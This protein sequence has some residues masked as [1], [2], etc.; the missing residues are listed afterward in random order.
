MHSLKRNFIKV[1]TLLAISFALPTWSADTQI[2][3]HIEALS[4]D[5]YYVDI[6]DPNI[7]F[8]TQDIVGGE[9]EKVYYILGFADETF[10]V[11]MQD[12]E[13]EV[14][15]AVRGDGLRVNKRAKGEIVTVEDNHAWIS[16]AVSAHP[17]AEYK[18][19]VK[20]HGE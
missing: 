12:I 18:L 14:A 19:T 13:G 5:Y 20:K 11:V 3:R 8:Q 2:L 15:Y 6:K 10:F 17:Y 16:I 9:H 1:L 7:A 4:R